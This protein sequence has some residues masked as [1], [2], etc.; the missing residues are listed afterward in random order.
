MATNE[1]NNQQSLAVPAVSNLR[2]ENGAS[3]VPMER[4]HTADMRA[5]RDDL[6]DAAEQSLNVILDLSIDGTIRW[7][8]SSWTE[9]IGTSVESVKDKPIADFLLFN[10]DAFADAVESMKK[11]DSK[12]RIIRF[13]VKVGPLSVLRQNAARKA[14]SPEGK[15]VEEENTTEEQVLN[16]EGQGIM[17]YDRSSGDESHVCTRANRCTRIRANDLADYVDV[18]TLQSSQRDHN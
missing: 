1:D 6:K 2:Q 15:D 8:S 10:K 14:G 3:R 18:T 13:R 11:D 7:V 16:L 17:V 9:V 5:E 12:S 4:S